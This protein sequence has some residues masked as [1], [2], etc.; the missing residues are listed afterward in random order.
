MKIRIKLFYAVL[1]IIFVACF[2]PAANAFEI[3]A[4]GSYWFPDISGHARYGLP[5]IAG[6]HVDIETDLGISNEGFASGEAYFGLGRHHVSLIYTQVDYTG[7]KLLERDIL[8]G[9]KTFNN[10]AHIYSEFKMDMFDAFYSYDLLD[11]ENIMAGFSIQ[12]VGQIKY[13]DGT[14]AI[15]DILQ[16][17]HTDFSAPVPMLGA[18]AHIGIMAE[19]IEA[20]ARLTGMGYS[21]NKLYDGLAEISVTPFPFFG[22]HAGYRIIGIDVEYDDCLADVTLSGPYACLSVSF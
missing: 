11:F 21:G 2:A 5:P 4:R 14:I 7:D 17:S 20:R 22:I 1:A 6:T 9:G 8:F 12:A 13:V 15:R 19:F 10:T 18:S 16:V 3:G